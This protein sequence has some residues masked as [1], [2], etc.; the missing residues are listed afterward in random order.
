MYITGLHFKRF[1]LLFAGSTGPSACKHGSVPAK[2]QLGFS[3]HF[4]FVASIQS[5]F[6]PLLCMFEA[7]S[8][9][10]LEVVDVFE[11]LI[12]CIFP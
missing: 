11:H 10:G 12:F 6:P 7:F 3:S 4:H 8:S 9:A 1:L 2:E 5:Q